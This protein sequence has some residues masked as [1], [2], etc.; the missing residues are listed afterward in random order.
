MSTMP[1]VKNVDGFP[2]IGWLVN[3]TTERGFEIPRQSLVDALKKVNIDENVAAKILDKNAAIRA[4]R[5]AAKGQKDVKHH[6][7]ADQDDATAMVI[8]HTTV[9]SDFNPDFNIKTKVVYDKG[10]RALNVTGAQKGQVEKSFEE[11][12]LTY[13][14]DQFRSIVLRYIKRECDAVTY[15]ETGNVY[16]VPVTKKQELRRLENLFKEV[17][18]N[19]K[20]IMKEEVNT[21]S[22]RSVM[23]DVSINEMK[24]HFK[25]M[26]KDFNDLDKTITPKVLETRLARYRE[27]KTKA[28]MFSMVLEGSAKDLNHDLDK[29]Q[30]LIQQ[31][32]LTE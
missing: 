25:S 7:V 11:K 18:A 26:E 28:E 4:V 10:T 22:V 29:L 1:I 20:L 2:I 19:V 32:V 6:K 23:W 31:K 15:L 24:D 9:D 30:K 5:E 13:A 17:G 14:S 16:F 3:W 21:K 12:K 27:L 8:A